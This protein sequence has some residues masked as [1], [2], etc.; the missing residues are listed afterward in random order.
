MSD[1]V[2]L[3]FLPTYTILNHMNTNNEII[4]QSCEHG[5]HQTLKPKPPKNNYRY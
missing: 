5:Q 1:Y 4:E 2:S 3:L